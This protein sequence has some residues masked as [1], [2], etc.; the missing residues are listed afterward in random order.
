MSMRINRTETTHQKANQKATIL[1]LNSD[2]FGMERDQQVIYTQD[3]MVLKTEEFIFWAKR[4]VIKQT[5]RD[6][7]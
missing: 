5:I 4:D 2:V 3:Y 6:Y 7:F 1:V